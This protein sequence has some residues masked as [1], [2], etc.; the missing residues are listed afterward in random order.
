MNSLALRSD[1]LDQV[2][3]FGAETWAPED[4]PLAMPRQSLTES[5][6]AAVRVATTPVDAAVV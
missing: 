5:Q 4:A 6:T 1:A 2:V 3:D